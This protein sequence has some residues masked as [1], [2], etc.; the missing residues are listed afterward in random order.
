MM[1]SLGAAAALALVLG[2][3]PTAHAFPLGFSVTGGIGAGYYSM[4]DLNSHLNAVRQANHIKLDEL[5]GGINFKADGRVWF[6]ERI[7]VSGGYEHLW[8]ESVSEGSSTTLDYKTPADVY[9]LGLV[10]TLLDLP[11]I[12]DLCVGVNRLSAKAVFGTNEVVSRRL[13]EFTGKNVGFEA[14]AE[15]HS[16]FL[17]PVEVGLQFGYRAL[18]MQTLYDKRHAVGF[19]ESGDQMSLDYSGFFFYL[20]S[21]IR[22]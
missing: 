11:N 4:A 20:T 18:K 1:K 21:S 5:A 8:G 3:A 13:A 2:A 9:T 12:V 22:I 19:F 16:N 17:N 10:G 15:A 14:Y 7:A 6:F